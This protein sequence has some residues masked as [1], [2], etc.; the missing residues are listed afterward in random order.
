MNGE[1][2]ACT[3]TSANKSVRG[4]VCIYT[5]DLVCKRRSRLARVPSRHPAFTSIKLTPSL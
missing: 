5:R 1:L 4:S 2:V 3:R